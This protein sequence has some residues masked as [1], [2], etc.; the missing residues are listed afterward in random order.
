MGDERLFDTEI[1]EKEY[2][3]IQDKYVT[4]PPGASG[5]PAVG[6]AI[7]L[8]VE[9]GVADWKEPG[10]SLTIPL[11]VVQEGMNKGKTIEWFAGISKDA[12]GITKRG[13][14]SFGIEAKVLRKIDGK[15]KINP[16]GFAGARARALFRR[17]MSNRNNLRS[18]LDSSS[19]LPLEKKAAAPATPPA[20]K[21]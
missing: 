1:G 11:T 15:I 21:S 3:D 14:Q 5:V 4:I 17:E 6:D 18:V 8:D 19:F 9:C 16:L 12:M 10:K 7:Y 13:L 20:A 2:E